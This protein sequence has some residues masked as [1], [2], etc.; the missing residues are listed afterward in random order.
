M[1]AGGGHFKHVLKSGSDLRGDGGLN[2]PKNFWTLPVNVD[3]S[4][5]GS[6]LTPPVHTVIGCHMPVHTA[7][8]ILSWSKCLM[9]DFLR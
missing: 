3:L 8:V 6:I 4:S 1:K 7:R 5:W 9:A 2:P